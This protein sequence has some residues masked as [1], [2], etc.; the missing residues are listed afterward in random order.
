MTE[1]AAVSSPAADWWEGNSDFW[2]RIIREHRDR[3]RT[4]LTDQA[5]L[6]AIGFCE[7][8]DVLDAGCGEGYLTRE[9]AGR[10]ARQVT[11]VDKS[12]ALIAAARAAA[13]EH[14]AARFHQADMATLSYPCGGFRSTPCVVPHPV[15]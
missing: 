4:E 15:R 9:I 6:S 14:R 11:G 7:G 12:A 1:A 13:Q 8:L 10:G 5:M 2:V 3:H